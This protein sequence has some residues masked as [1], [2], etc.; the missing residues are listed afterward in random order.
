[1]KIWVVADCV[2]AYCGYMQ[3]YL[4]KAGVRGQ[5]ARVVKDLCQHLYGTWRNIT[6][7][8]FFTQYTL[9]EELLQNKLTIVGTLRK[10]NA[11]IP[12]TMLA[13]RKR[14]VHT[15]IFGFNEQTTVAFYAPK[16][17]RSV[18]MLSTMHHDK[19]VEPQM[20]NKPDVILDYNKTKK[21]VDTLH[22]FCCQY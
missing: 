13:D 10:N 6:M 14:Q 18:I 21:A 12:L 22:K 9:A 1:M 20:D 7:D 5:G 2:T 3:A 11:V 16:K 15:T 17:N 4:K 8:N 19:K